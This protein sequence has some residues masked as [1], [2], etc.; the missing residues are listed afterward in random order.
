MELSPYFYIIAG[1]LAL[2]SHF[3]LPSQAAKPAVLDD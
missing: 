3:F 1:S 2:I